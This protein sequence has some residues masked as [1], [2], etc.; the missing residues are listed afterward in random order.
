MNSPCSIFLWGF[1]CDGA[2]KG[3]CVGIIACAHGG[4]VD[5]EGAD[6]RLG[7]VVCKAGDGAAGSQG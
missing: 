4:G 1:I 2:G 5:D 6:D 3:Q 7:T